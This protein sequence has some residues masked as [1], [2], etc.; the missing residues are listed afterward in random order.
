M[1]AMPK[2]TLIPAHQRG[3]FFRHYPLLQESRLKESLLQ[4][5]P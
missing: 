3:V 4:G 5:R 1:D 2:V